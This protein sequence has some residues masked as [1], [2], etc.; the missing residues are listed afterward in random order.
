MLQNK[1]NVYQLLDSFISYLQSI[2]EGITANSLSVYVVPLRSYFSYHDIDIIPSK[3]KRKVFLPKI[4]REDEQSLD[5]S[6][7]RKIL[8]NCS[9]RRLKAY[10]LVLASGGMR[11]VEALAIRNKDVDFES[12]PTRIHLRKE[13]SKIKIGRDIYISDEAT[14]Y[15]KPG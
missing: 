1:I 14:Q 7:I 9:N 10:L 3:F 11:T 4:P 8:L 6:D 13:Y 12:S 5:S 15:L 2:I